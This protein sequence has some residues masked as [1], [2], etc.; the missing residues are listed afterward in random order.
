M[1]GFK[2]SRVS[3]FQSKEQSDVDGRKPKTIARMEGL[4]PTL[5]PN[6]LWFAHWD[7]EIHQLVAVGIID[8]G[9]EEAC[10][11]RG[12]LKIADVKE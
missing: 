4:L 6:S 12:I 10:A 1:T 2:V 8:S 11:L 9:N 7:F 5:A 3:K